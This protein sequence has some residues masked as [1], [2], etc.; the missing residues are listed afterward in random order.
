MHF[1]RTT[2][3]A[4]AVFG[5][6]ALAGCETAPTGSRMMLTAQL[7]GAQEVPPKTTGGSGTAQVEYD[8]ATNMLH[9]T[10]T[11]S[12]LTGPA[13]AAHI[14]GPAAAGANAGV[15]VPF[16]VGPSPITGEAPITPAQAGDLLAGLWYVNVHTAANPGGEIRGQLSIKH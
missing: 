15:L 6:A 1:R 7:S 4:A 10:V 3:I 12:G 9:W 14:H 13:T 11:Y 8:R 5:L 2:L 16:K